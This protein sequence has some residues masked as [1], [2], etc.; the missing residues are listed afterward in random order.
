[1]KTTLLLFILVFAPI[2]IMAQRS[3]EERLTSKVIDCEDIAG[4]SAMAFVDFMN[5]GYLDSARQVI[6]FWEGKCG[7]SEPVM[8]S[9]ILWTIVADE[10]TEEIY[11]ITML[12]YIYKYLARLEYTG[13]GDFRTVYDN[14]AALYGYVPLNSYFDRATVDLAAGITEFDNDL[15]RLYSLLYSDKIDEFFITL[16]KPEY[17]HYLVRYAYDKEVE[18]INKQFSLHFSIFSGAYIPSGNAA[19]LGSHPEF[20]FSI[21]AQKDKFTYDLR[22]AFRWGPTDEPYHFHLS[23]YDTIPTTYYFG[24]FIGFDVFYDLVGNGRNK[25]LLLGGIAIDGFD[26]QPY[27]NNYYSNYYS[28]LAFNTNFGLMYR[29][30]LSKGTYLFLSYRYNLVNYNNS[31]RSGDYAGIYENISGNWHSLNIGIGWVGNKM[32]HDALKRLRYQDR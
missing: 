10:L 31:L 23:Y 30:F 5:Q 13:H 25:L 9:K 18:T 26:T 12:D 2:P 11:G 28:V 15:E 21:G 8:R 27:D 32:K 17:A 6:D 14:S 29:I 19:I 1:M 4:N 22:I 20:G 24:G 3:L 7:L 16:Q